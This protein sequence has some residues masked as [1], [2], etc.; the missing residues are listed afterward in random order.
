MTVY[1]VD[2]SHYNVM[3]NI[4]GYDFVFQKCTQGSTYLD[5]TYAGRH[6]SVRQAGKVFG[7]YHFFVT[8]IPVQQ[9]LNWFLQQAN[10]QPGDVAICDFE[11]DGAW[12]NFSPSQLAGMASEFMAGLPAANR[13]LLY[14]TV[15]T[16]DSIVNPW[17]V[18]TRDGLWLAHPGSDPGGELFWQSGISEGIDSDVATGFSTA[19]DL[20]NWGNH[21]MNEQSIAQAVMQALIDF[22][23]NSN[24]NL[25]DDGI[26]I[27]ANTAQPIDPTA[28]SQSLAPILAPIVVQQIVQ[29]VSQNIAMAVV[30]AIRAQFD[31]S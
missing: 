23:P 21:T 8:T 29:E 5:P 17:H 10:L 3:P 31:K 6:T 2:L 13:G 16:R 20:Q 22:R 11:D 1:G 27:L 30:A 18:N 15:G 25:W 24:R 19:I 14:C 4:S 7:A 12:I 26:Q 28:L 9:Q